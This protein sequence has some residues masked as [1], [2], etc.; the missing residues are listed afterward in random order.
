MEPS[1]TKKYINKLEKVRRAATRFGKNDQRQTSTVTAMMD[2]H[3]WKSLEHC[4]AYQQLTMFY[5]INHEIVNIS[6]PS[7]IIPVSYSIRNSH[8]LKFTQLYCHTHIYFTLESS[9][10]G[11]LYLPQSSCLHLCPLSSQLFIRHPAYI[12]RF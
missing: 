3:R 4:R 1:H 9:G 12:A 6:I 7:Y 2:D 10:C 11:I 5:K 8:I